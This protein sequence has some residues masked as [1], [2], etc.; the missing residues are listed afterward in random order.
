[1]REIIQNPHHDVLSLLF[2]FDEGCGILEIASR[3]H[4]NDPGAGYDKIVDEVCGFIVPTLF[5]AC[6]TTDSVSRLT[7]HFFYQRIVNR[8][9]EKDR[10][11]QLANAHFRECVALKRHRE[12]GHEHAYRR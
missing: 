5:S 1:M 2:A 11:N 8:S 6:T 3:A 7:N 12:C 10:I 4:R 9:S